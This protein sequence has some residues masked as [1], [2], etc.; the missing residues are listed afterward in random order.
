MQ[1]RGNTVTFDADL[2]APWVYE[3]AGGQYVPGC[4]TAIGRIKDGKLVA[5]VTYAEYNGVGLVCGIAGEGN[6]ATRGF[7]WL[8]FDYPFNQL[9]AKRITTFVSTKNEKSQNFN[10]KLGFV[11]EGLLQDACND[12]DVWVN[13]ILKRECKWI[14]G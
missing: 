9:Q 6:W 4:C 7:L 13:R 8:I 2:V 3:R 14:K 11:N 5:G 1:I 12:G 10:L